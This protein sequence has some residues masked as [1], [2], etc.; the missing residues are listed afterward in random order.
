MFRLRALRFDGI[1]TAIV[2]AFVA[3]LLAPGAGYAQGFDIS[4]GALVTA[5]MSHSLS[6]FH[7]GSVGYVAITA[8]IAAGWHINAEKPLESYLI[9]TVLEVNAP[10][11][12]E[13]VRLLYPEPVLRKL[14]ISETK[15]AL[16]D[17]VAV[18]GALVRVGP[19]VKPGSYRITATIR[20]QG[21]N[22]LTCVEPASASADDTI[23]VGTLEEG[24][25]Q[26]ETELFSKPPFA[27]DDGAPAGVE[28]APP[29]TG[30]FGK[31]IA[32]R[33]L[34][35]TF[36][37]IFFSGLALNLT[38][39]IYPLIPITIS[40]FGGQAGGRASR[41]F[42]LAFL[43]VFGMSITYS[44]LGTI[45]AMTGSLFG[46]VLQNP[47]V[48]LALAAILVALAL[49]MFGLWE[50]RMPMFLARRTGSA[51]QGYAGAIV[52]GLTMGI[53]AAPC[54]GPFVL[55]LLTYVGEMG[56]PLLGFFMFFT[57]AWGIGLPFLVLGTL[58]GSLSRLP[59]S[60]AWMIWVRKIF[61]FVL[62]AMALYF[63]RQLLSPR[64]VSIGYAVIAIA[65]GI[66]LGWIDRTAGAGRGFK[67]LKRAIGIAGVALGAAF[68]VF[69]AIRGGADVQPRGI[70]WQPFSEEAVLG[71]AREGKMVVI[72]F[73]A[74]WCL[75]CRELD[76]KT[77][78]D[79][80][81]VE[82]SAG[83]VPLRVD[84]T[85]SGAA[86]TKIKNDYRVRGVPTIIFIDGAGSERAELRA[87]GFIDAAEFIKRVEA[88]AGV[89]AAGA[90]PAGSRTER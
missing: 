2:F 40:Y 24:V 29:E 20:Y 60:G 17:G 74:A 84:L 1:L 34:A 43:Y 61:G 44:V 32:E 47:F 19:D 35:L 41:V 57:L 65:G 53:V 18:F 63:I 36:L 52:M 9:P 39:C 31:M 49:S 58:S 27:G 50:I 46:S 3:T 70:A 5:D 88:L 38:P 73:S 8:D 13:I 66:Y 23:R 12:I 15:M 68:L 11:G 80:E 21:C 4:G 56:K 10:A 82:L 90:S 72:D 77:F 71:A 14:E 76:R 51:R 54:I 22:N 25:E 83:F 30:D 78:V 59:R 89:P 26:L 85:K 45:A 7:P 79:P 86:E 6:V 64:L 55:G 33:G 62:V 87:T 42:L 37:V 69:P 28:A 67:V 48:V 81:A 75:P 16:Y